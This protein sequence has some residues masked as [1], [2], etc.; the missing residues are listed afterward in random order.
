MGGQGQSQE[1]VCLKFSQVEENV[2][3][4]LV[5]VLVFQGH[6]KPARKR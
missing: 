3:A 2:K 6:D 5:R 4:V 1:E